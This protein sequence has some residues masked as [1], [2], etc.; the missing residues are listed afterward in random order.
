[1]ALSGPIMRC[2]SD[3]ESYVTDPV[4]RLRQNFLMAFWR[5]DTVFKTHG[6]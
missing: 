2:H 5:G 3:R 1:M 4:K 6:H